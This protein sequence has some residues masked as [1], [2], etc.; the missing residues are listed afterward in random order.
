[1][2]SKAKYDMPSPTY[3]SAAQ[4]LSTLSLLLQ[5]TSLLPQ[6]AA[7]VAGAAPQ[8]DYHPGLPGGHIRCRRLTVQEPGLS[9]RG[10]EFD[11]PR[12]H[13][14]KVAAASSSTLGPN[15]HRLVVRT[16]S[17]G[18]TSVRLRLWVGCLFPTAGNSAGEGSL[19][20]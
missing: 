20:T 2:H 19:R 14:P 9:T 8:V 1:M 13:H 11:S 7:A 10:L 18:V 16:R 15:P 6:S 5:H 3:D 17:E 4:E 12:Q